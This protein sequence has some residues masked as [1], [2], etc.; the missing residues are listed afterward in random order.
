MVNLPSLFVFY[1][2]HINF[3]DFSLFQVPELNLKLNIN[4]RNEKLSIWYLSTLG[5]L[6]M[7]ETTNIYG[8]SLLSWF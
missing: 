7:L 4:Y 6:T 3:E 2:K 1:L 5:I 8:T